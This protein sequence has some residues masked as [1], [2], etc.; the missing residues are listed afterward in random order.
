M[1]MFLGIA[2]IL[3]L[4]VAII[5]IP[6]PKEENLDGVYVELFQL[7]QA[8]YEFT[9]SVYWKENSGLVMVIPVDD[10][11]NM[12]SP[13]SCRLNISIVLYDDNSEVINLCSRNHQDFISRF[14]LIKSTTSAIY[15]YS[16]NTVCSFNSNYKAVMPRLYTYVQSKFPNIK[17]TFDGS[18]IMAQN[19]HKQ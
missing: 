16:A 19:M 18:R 13:N 3:V 2:L 10:N 14:K 12:Y 1:A 9:N 11:N 15:S 8:V 4:I 6:K 5:K 7:L 17:F